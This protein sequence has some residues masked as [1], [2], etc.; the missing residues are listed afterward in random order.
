MKKFYALI[1]LVFALT[2]CSTPQGATSSA[3]AKSARD[4]ERAKQK[5]EEQE[6]DAAT[7]QIAVDALN[8]H[9]F[10]L[11]ADQLI[12][13]RGRTAFVNT[14]TNFV[15]MNKDKAT[16]QI[17]ANGMIAGPNGVG[18]ITVDGNVSDVKMKTSKKGNVDF[19]FN[20]QGIG[21]SAQVFITL[22]NGSNEASATV[23]P[24]FN[25]NT[26]TLN[27]NIVTL[28]ESS[29]FKGRTLF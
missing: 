3:D 23:Y 8:A 7:Y 13:R 26:I 21:I 25:S 29:V 5:A 19:S 20:V 16:V 22:T 10:V 6:Y 2:A 15:M 18:G 27:G 11:E 9:E 12:S 17:A 24:N 4:E 14:T 1:A 28:G